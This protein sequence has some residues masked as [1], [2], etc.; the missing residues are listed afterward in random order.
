MAHSANGLS[1]LEVTVTPSQ[2]SFFAGEELR[3]F[4]TF[5]NTNQ[6]IPA[7][8]PLPSTS[9]FEDRNGSSSFLGQHDNRRIAS[10][11]EPSQSPLKHG[12]SQSTD[13]RGGLSG[14]LQRNGFLDDSRAGQEDLSSEIDLN[15]DS[16]P[17]R[18]RMIGRSARPL[19]AEPDQPGSST[20]RKH[21]KSSS[22]VSFSPSQASSPDR[23]ACGSREGKRGSEIGIG[24]PSRPPSNSHLTIEDCSYLPIFGNVKGHLLR[25][26]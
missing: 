10:Q 8:Q 4:I 25:V 15:G 24:R 11:M 5:T 22:M 18:R 26:A 19:I 1:P 16:L 17:T 21:T 23:L 13:L 6:P 7:S 2:S 9:R 3:C 20:P 12:K 14:G